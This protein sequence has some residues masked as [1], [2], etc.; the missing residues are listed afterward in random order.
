MCQLLRKKYNQK[1][2]RDTLSLFYLFQLTLKISFIICKQNNEKNC[3]CSVLQPSAVSRTERQDHSGVSSP[4]RL[5]CVAMR[6]MYLFY[7]KS[8]TLLLA[9]VRKGIQ[10]MRVIVQKQS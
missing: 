1:Q 4:C 7:F 8:I 2:N 6:A 10:V 9:P 5:D 3:S